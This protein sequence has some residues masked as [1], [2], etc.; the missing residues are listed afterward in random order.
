MCYLLFQSALYISCDQWYIKL[1]LVHGGW[2]DWSEWEA[3]SATCDIGIQ[4]RHRTCSNPTP[5]RFGDH[6][7]GDTMSDRL[8]FP[9]ACAGMYYNN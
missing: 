6:C 7:F 3:C 2:S 1:Y 4:Q 8:C 5:E 9:G